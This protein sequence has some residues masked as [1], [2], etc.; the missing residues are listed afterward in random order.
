M[1][2]RERACEGGDTIPHWH[3]QGEMHECQHCGT[4][5]QWDM[6]DHPFWGFEASCRQIGSG[7]PASEAERADSTHRSEAQ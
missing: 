7:T 6:V 5:V 2:E 4:Q 1:S 3:C